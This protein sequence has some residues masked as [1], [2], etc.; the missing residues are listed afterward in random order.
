[1]PRREAVLAG[2]RKAVGQ[3]DDLAVAAA[4]L[5]VFEAEAAKRAAYKIRRLWLPKTVGGFSLIRSQGGTL[6]T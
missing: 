2:F 3:D 6:L 4:H 1:M 5:P